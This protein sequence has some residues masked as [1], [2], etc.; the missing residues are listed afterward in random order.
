MIQ[1]RFVFFPDSCYL[2]VLNHTQWVLD[3]LAFS[4]DFKNNS[5]SGEIVACGLNNVIKKF[6]F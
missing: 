1:L 2:V 6:I 4:F 3:F 5:F